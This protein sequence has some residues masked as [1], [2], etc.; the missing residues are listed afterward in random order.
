MMVIPVRE[1][2]GVVRPDHALGVLDGVGRVDVR[3]PLLQLWLGPSQDVVGVGD[4]ERVTAE[5]RLD[6]NRAS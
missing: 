6:K 5:V 2:S 4:V 1:I 3:P